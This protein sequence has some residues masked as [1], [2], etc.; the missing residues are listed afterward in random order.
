MVKL[1]PSRISTAFK[2]S[3]LYYFKY[4]KK[5]P[6]ESNSGAKKGTITHQILECLVRPNR[7]SMVEAI[8]KAKDPFI[9]PQIRRMVEIWARKLEIFEESEIKMIAKFILVAL[10][11]DFYHDGCKSLEAEY[12]FNVEGNGWRAGGFIDKT[13]IYEDGVKIVDYKT[14]KA[15]FTDEELEFNLQN[16][17]YT[18]AAQTRFPDLPVTFEFQFLK[19]ADNPIAK[20]P[21]ISKQEM[22]GFLEWCGHISEHLDNFDLVK[23]YSNPAKKNKN[24]FLCGGE[25]GQLTKKGVQWYICP[26]KYPYIYFALEENGKFI[27]SSRDKWRLEKMLKEGQVIVEKSH[28]GCPIWSHLW[29]PK[30]SSQAA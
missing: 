7:R 1:S 18:Y 24:Y 28:D 22:A 10:N 27:T 17:F 8:R 13:A 15:Q 30:D 21:S 9:F 14:S 23:A 29:K 19:F 11:L 20:A 12:E 2:C 4:I 3:F 25:I 16:Y 5:V 26:Q 6:D